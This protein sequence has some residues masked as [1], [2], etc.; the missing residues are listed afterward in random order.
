MEQ[1]STWEANSRLVS[2]YIPCFLFNQ[3]VHYRGPT[4]DSVLSQMNPVHIVTHSFCK[5]RFNNIFQSAT[6]CRK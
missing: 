1:S 5:I 2:Q 4:T 6:R 3:K